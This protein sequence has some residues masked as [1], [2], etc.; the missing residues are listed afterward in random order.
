M[1]QLQTKLKLKPSHMKRETNN[2]KIQL[3][4]RWLGHQMEFEKK[5]VLDWTMH[6]KRTA[7]CAVMSNSW[8]EAVF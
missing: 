4:L 5:T 2:D 1:A 6:V 3:G 8:N 7:A